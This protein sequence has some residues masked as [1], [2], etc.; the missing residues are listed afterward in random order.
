MFDSIND[1][2]DFLKDRFA[3]PFWL[4]F[5]LSWLILNWP[6]TV[7]ALF[8]SH[9]F[10]Q[11]FIS[12][13]LNNTSI[14]MHFLFPLGMGFFYSAF[15]STLRESME[16]LAKYIRGKVIKLLNARNLYESISLKQHEEQIRRFQIQ[17]SKLQRDNQKHE[18][19]LDE[20][21]SLTQE[22]KDLRSSQ[23]KISD[24]ITEKV[25][26]QSGLDDV[27]KNLLVEQLKKAELLIAYETDEKESNTI[28]SMATSTK[29]HVS[30]ETWSV[31]GWATDNEMALEANSKFSILKTLLLF[32]SPNAYGGAKRADVIKM[33]TATLEE[34]IQL[35]ISA[36]YLTKLGNSRYSL[37]ETGKSEIQKLKQ[38]P[39][40]SAFNK[41]LTDLQDTSKKEIINALKAHQLK[42][43]ELVDKTT[44]NPS[45]STLLKELCDNGTIELRGNIYTLATT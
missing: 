7:T 1:F 30:S 4:S 19:L 21:N 43:K 17:F 34:T 44:F 29:N 40:L 2:K 12:N 6:I 31:D 14:W 8:Q 5:I 16:V 9:D 36:K 22:V 33:D 20:N 37:T 23:I 35:C 3:S 39:E 26:N 45:F 25:L 11:Q 28:D 10:N 15:S 42:L 13:Y 18:E 27:Q 32:E 41:F 24:I 38:A